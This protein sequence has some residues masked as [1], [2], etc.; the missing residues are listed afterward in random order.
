VSFAKFNLHS[1]VKVTIAIEGDIQ[2]SYI[3]L[4][5]NNF[6][7]LGLLKKDI[8]AEQVTENFLGEVCK[9]LIRDS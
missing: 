8:H 3:H 6:Q 2:N 4:K 7:D 5:F 1:K 9:Y